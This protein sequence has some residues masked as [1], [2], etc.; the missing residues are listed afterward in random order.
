MIAARFP[1]APF[2]LF[3]D[4]QHIRD[5]PCLQQVIQAVATAP[6]LPAVEQSLASTRTDA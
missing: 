1:G 4:I 2:A 3:R 5:N 6:D